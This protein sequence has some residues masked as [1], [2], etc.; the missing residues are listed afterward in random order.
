MGLRFKFNL[1]MLLALLLG[2][3]IDAAY[4]YVVLRN[5]ARRE[6][7]GE[8]AI[9]MSQADVI[10]RYTDREIAPL[11]AEQSRLNFAPQTIP[12]WVAQTTFRAL[13]TK[14]PEYSFREPALNPTN[15]SD[16]PTQ[17]QTDIIDV[18]ARQP[19]LEEFVSERQGPTGPILQY[20]RPIR[21]TDKSCLECHSTPA[22][23]PASMVERYGRTNGF[24]WK[25]GDLV[26]AQI[27]SVPMR[28]PLDRA[29]TTFL[30]SLI[31]LCAAFVLMTAVLNLLLHVVILRPVRRI[32][33]TANEVS[34][35]KRDAPEIEVKGK[36]EM[37]AL[38]ASFN[39]MRKSLD[40]AM[41]L[42]S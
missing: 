18:F 42:L 38:A 33:T 4:S 8:A 24:G 35:G 21:I 17:A 27:V 11:L 12:F 37:A 1:A 2:L 3:G 5:N 22:A 32:V 25:F 34:L 19:Q 20:A 16:R 15:P 30:D 41:D 6:V 31:G 23:A 26:G 10:S 13:Q 40:H 14:F 7:L 39:R 29:Y 9:M 28:V 36:D